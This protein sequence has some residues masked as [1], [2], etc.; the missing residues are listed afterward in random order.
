MKAFVVTVAA[1]GWLAAGQANAAEAARLITDIHSVR[2]E[3]LKVL[4]AARGAP[5]DKLPAYED[6]LR[7][8]QLRMLE[9]RG[10]ATAGYDPV[11]AVVSPTN[12]GDGGQYACAYQSANQMW[13]K[14]ETAVDAIR[15]A[16]ATG[17]EAH[18]DY[19]TRVHGWFADQR[20]SCL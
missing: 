16:S 9:L 12:P 4:D 8:L 18:R 10:K 3:A 5:T 14:L 20:V 19:L 7:D 1:L 11:K 17:V 13:R 6:P 15:L 2:V